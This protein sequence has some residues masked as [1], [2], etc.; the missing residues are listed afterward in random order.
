VSPAD[1]IELP[2][3]LPHT[4]SVSGLTEEVVR[5][6]STTEAELIVGM[7]EANGIA[8][9][10]S[11]DDAGGLEPQWQLTQGVRVLVAPE[12][13]AEARRLVAEASSGSE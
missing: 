7:L 2:D 5:A 10:V 8:A 4:S 6:S 9:A 11:A 12:D 1:R 3:G 13:T